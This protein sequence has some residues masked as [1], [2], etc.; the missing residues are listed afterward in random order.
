[1]RLA[2]ST[3]SLSAAITYSQQGACVKQHLI[4][5]AGFTVRYTILKYCNEISKR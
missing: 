5:S 3:S 2:S 4:V 1:M